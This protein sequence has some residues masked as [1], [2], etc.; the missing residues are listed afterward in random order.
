MRLLLV[1]IPTML[2]VGSLFAGAEL[3]T[4]TSEDGGEIRAEIL[5]ANQDHVWIE[6][7]DGRSKP[8]V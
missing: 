3:R 2:L 5:R 7:E 1:F 8:P 4:I 6:R